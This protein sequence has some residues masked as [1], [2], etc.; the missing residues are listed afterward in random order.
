MAK[1]E[2]IRHGTVYFFLFIIFF[3]T[4][5]VTATPW[6]PDVNKYNIF[7]TYSSTDSRVTESCRMLYE[8]RSLQKKGSIRI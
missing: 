6:I 8:Q 3:N 7:I 4:Q 5:A 1:G 2:Y